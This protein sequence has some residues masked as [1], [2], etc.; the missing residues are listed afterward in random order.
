M[1]HNRDGGLDQAGAPDPRTEYDEPQR[2][3]TEGTSRTGPSPYDVA[4]EG[5]PDE[6]VITKGEREKPGP[7]AAETGPDADSPRDHSESHVSGTTADQRAAGGPYPPDRALDD[8]SVARE[9]P[10]PHGMSGSL[11]EVEAL[12]ANEETGTL[13]GE[14]LHR[15]INDE[16]M[17]DDMP[18]DEES[19]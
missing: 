2:R 3:E 11:E 8:Q 7:T 9:M 16:A 19:A 5:T 18:G 1:A 13:G 15:R 6:R 14:A 12:E 17:R 4:P 10:A